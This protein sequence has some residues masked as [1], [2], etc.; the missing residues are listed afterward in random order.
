MFGPDTVAGEELADGSAVD[1]E[2]FAQHKDS[3][4]R[5]VAGDERWLLLGIELPR[6]APLSKK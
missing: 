2:L 5:L 6:R 3:G 4:H 1:A